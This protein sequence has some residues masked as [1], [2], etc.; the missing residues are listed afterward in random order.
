M[1]RIMILDDSPDLVFV[2]KLFL[3]T[4]DYV[5][6]TLID[7]AKIHEEIVEFKPDLLILDIYLCSEDGRDICKKLKNSPQ[8]EGLKILVYSAS[9]H[10]LKEYKSFHADDFIE[11]PFDLSHLEQKVRSMVSP[12]TPNRKTFDMA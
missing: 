4:K 6:K 2:L 3:E 5:V 12:A 7:P 1:D 8:T 11:K 9:S 10:I